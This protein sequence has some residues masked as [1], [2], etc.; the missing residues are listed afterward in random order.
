MVM[1]TTVGSRDP[2]QSPNEMLFTILF[3]TFGLSMFSYS[4]FSL[5][6]LIFDEQF[7]ERHRRRSMEREVS[8]LKEHHIVCGLGRM[9]ITICDYLQR[10]RK[11][12]V[13]I[14]NNQ[15][16][17]VTT[18]S[19][20]Q[21]KYVIGDATDD[22]ILRKAGIGQAKSLASV[23]PSDADNVYVV[24]SARLLNDKLQIIARAED[25][26]SAQKIQR[27]GATRVISPFSSGGV[28]IARFML[29]PSLEDFLEVTN[30]GMDDLE[31]AEVFIAEKSPYA[32][33]ILRETDLREQG[34]M[35]IGIRRSTG[36][37]L[38]PPSSVA[39]IEAGDTLIIFGNNTSIA[40]VISS[41]EKT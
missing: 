11:P 1:L 27:A 25:E 29:N 12:F 34:L 21:W 13:V 8:K 35:V 32:N 18:C 3:L 20:K 7:Q 28:K 31:L 26:K 40:K 16:R 41:T 10:K 33:Q 17:L 39:L 38:M 9:G 37:R 2:A 15:D 14:D 19:D 4:L 23:L 22:D 36:E 6:Q 30:D 24:L 5:G